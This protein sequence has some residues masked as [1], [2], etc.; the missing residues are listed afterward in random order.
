M[1]NAI[2]IQDVK[3]GQKFYM[4]N[5]AGLPKYNANRT[6]LMTRNNG[7]AFEFIRIEQDKMYTSSTLYPQY[8]VII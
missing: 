8:V 4:L 1:K 2:L 5:K 6:F 7:K 3:V